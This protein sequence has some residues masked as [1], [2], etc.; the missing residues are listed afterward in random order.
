M[1]RPSR[2]SLSLLAFSV[3]VA[4]VPGP[5]APDVTAARTLELADEARGKASSRPFGV[6]SATPQGEARGESEVAV[7]LNRP[8]HALETA[9]DE[10][11]IPARIEAIGAAK[12]PTGR[13]QWMGTQA[14]VFVPEGTGM[15]GSGG[16]LP[17]ATSYR[18][19]VPAGTR[20]L[21]GSTLVADYSFTF[22]TA[23]PKVDLG[24]GV[25]VH[26]LP[27]TPTLRMVAN[28]PI[29]VRELTRATHFV[30]T[31][32][33]RAP[34]AVRITPVAA[35]KP[36]SASAV[37]AG[38][39]PSALTD[40]F[41][42]T[43]V[44]PLPLATDF[45]LRV[46]AGLH[47]LQGPL[48]TLAEM[49]FEVSTYGPLRVQEIAC[50]EA[51]DGRCAPG[52]SVRF[53][54]SNPVAWKDLRDAITVSGRP[55]PK[56]V[57]AAYD[58]ETTSSFWVA[59]PF[60]AGGAV[61]ASIRPGIKDKYGQTLQ[62][63]ASKTF[64]VGDLPSRLELGVEGEVFERK[65]GGSTRTIPVRSVNLD[66]YKLGAVALTEEQAVRAVGDQRRSGVEVAY[67]YLDGLAPKHAREVRPQVGKNRS[68]LE[69]VTLDGVLGKANGAG[70]VGVYTA[71]TYPGREQ[72]ERH[73][74]SLYRVTDLA[75]SAKLSRYGGVIW[76]TRL[77]DAAPV[78]G[79]V[80]RIRDTQEAA[81]LFE[82][83]ADANGLVN[84]PPGD[85]FT[86]S[87][88]ALGVVVAAS[89]DDWTYR[90][91]EDPNHG[92]VWP[93]MS[94]EL[95]AV[96]MLF[97]DR[98]LYRR[99]ESI[100]AKILFREEQLQGLQ[101]PAG[102]GVTLR[103][104]DADGTTIFEKSGQLGAFGE[105]AFEI[106]LGDSAPLGNVSLRAHIQDRE[107]AGT[108]YES[109]QI[110]AYRPAEFKTTTTFAK[111][112]H[113]RGD[114]AACTA[115]G[116]Y[117]FGA[118]LSQGTAR[119]TLSRRATWFSPPGQEGRVVDD[120]SFGRDVRAAGASYTVIS[121]ADPPQAGGAGAGQ[122]QG[123]AALSARG[124]ATHELT[125]RMPS[126]I[127]PESVTCEADI[128][129]VSRQSIAAE[130]TT[131]VHPGTFYLALDTPEDSIVD[132]NA[133]LAPKVRTVDPEG[134]IRNGIAV[135]LELIRRTWS[136]VYEEQGDGG[137][138]DT[139]VKDVLV[140]SCEVRT[141]Q[142]AVSC[143]L[144]AGEAGYYLVHAKAVDER[145]NP[146]GASYGFYVS[147]ESGSAGW[148]LRDDASLELVLDRASYE[149]GQTAKVLVKNPFT[150]A[151]ALVTVERANTLQKLR[152]H[153][154]GPAPVIKLPVGADV[155]PN[156]YVTVELV[157]GRIRDGADPA[158]PVTEPASSARA[159]RATR[160][161]RKRAK[162]A[163]RS[164]AVD[165]G[166]PAYRIG[167]I[168]LPVNP[169]SRRLTATVK[170]PR[171]QYG[172]GEQLDADIDVR[173]VAGKGAETD[174][175]FYVV[176]EGVL[177]LSGYKT[178]D[179]V[180]RFSAGLPL[181]V[182]TFESRGEL[183]KLLKFRAALGEDKGYDG[184]G[185]GDGVRAD[186]RTTA[187]FT[188]VKTD[189]NGHAHVRSKLP[190]GLT[191]Y[192]L[193]AVVAGK[194]DRFGFGESRVTT[195]RPLM[196]RPALP[197]FLRAGDHIDAG[198]IVTAKGLAAGSVAVTLAVQGAVLEGPAVQTVNLGKDTSAEVRFKIRVDKVGK[199]SF[200]LRAEGM[201]QKDA[202]TLEKPVQ[203]PTTF[204]T[205]A[206]AG[207]TE[208]AVG[209]QL[210]NLDAIRA[211][212]GGL[213]VRLA[214][215]ALVGVES[216]VDQLTEYPH[217]CTE[218][219]SSR[220]LPL[221]ESKELAAFFGIQ[222]PGKPER[223]ADAAIAQIVE[224][225]HGDGGFGYWP[226]SP[227]SDPW[228]S[229]YATFVLGRAKAA[230]RAVPPRV[231]ENALSYV[232]RSLRDDSPHRSW[233]S[234]AF[235]V[236][237]LAS[238][239]QP[240]QTGPAIGKKGQP[241]PQ[242]ES[243]LAGDIHALMPPPDDAP[244]FAR[245]LLAH[246]VAAAH[247]R[248]EDQLELAKDLE[249]S[250]QITPTG[251]LVAEPRSETDRLLRRR[252]LDSD[253][254]TTAMVLRALVAIDPVHPLAPKLAKG[255]LA[256][257]RHGQYESTQEAAWV[258]LALDDYRK[259]YEKDA[260]AFDARLFLG[261]TLA[262]EAGFHGGTARA[263]ELS[264]SMDKLFAG[265]SRGN[266]PLAFQVMG[267]GTLFYE[268]RLRYARK[269]NP[270]SSLSR[271]FTVQRWLRAVDPAK[272]QEATRTLP[273]RSETAVAAGSLVLIDV[274]VVND[275][276]AYQVV[277]D[278]P[279]PA[280]LEA[281]NGA[282]LTS[283][284]SLGS[285][286]DAA[287]QR[288]DEEETDDFQYRSSWVG[289]ERKTDDDRVLTYV[290]D[291][292][293]GLHHYRYLARATTRGQFVVPPARAECMYEPEIFGRTAGYSFTV[294]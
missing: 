209:E 139:Q 49:D 88:V 284:R 160:E 17:M 264:L 78:P 128:T 29:D 144:R 94:R 159:G 133:T 148:A 129:D 200:T 294:R 246:A 280:G 155:R 108:A 21:D 196:V 204:E 89:G 4:C 118:P 163:D 138:Y 211:D 220:L 59:G 293:A 262:H 98:G 142:A 47:G 122:D 251:A 41:D 173:D 60:P 188:S 162:A 203:I 223:L 116:E 140:Q 56:S 168:A 63:G 235:A 44:T 86:G 227:S 12:P 87:G 274:L 68:A 265:D 120:D 270:T 6:V 31:T 20:A 249:R 193:M 107:E 26:T 85:Y 66:A 55:A 32:N 152:V 114:K 225:Q 104:S 149:V 237:V 119:F 151:D 97:T 292:P 185:G 219:L 23:R 228:L 226:S 74:A 48:P 58:K 158:P 178:P 291:L 164:K 70:V 135:R 35:P 289:Y 13:W 125:L 36:T 257:R 277:L 194:D 279:L 281:V 10:T 266:A 167:T 25:D 134:K 183:A 57:S 96:G 269:E 229:P 210:G 33:K 248:K 109:V 245:A 34:I 79:A 126:Q 130:S 52:G 37:A 156:A 73:T 67:R 206:L 65:P 165:L 1:R 100:H 112:S 197:R 208:K 110:A 186:F 82:G 199:A 154:K 80:I 175:T 217:G 54:L 137:H 222:M 2:S 231:L 218:Q 166:G 230:G 11:P 14:F 115:R 76:V 184:G 176:D 212:S 255:L 19:T 121:S 51:E 247:L 146:I 53:V 273:A 43:P 244:L 290:E 239:E 205:V 286:L 233:A 28:Q 91:L 190:D 157:R 267:S 40:T 124:E 131:L 254:R 153:V 50:S 77:S 39:Q 207:E 38:P 198:A 179:P 132:E 285:A 287:E 202:A 236:D 278:D 102:K 250:V 106:P 75:I 263:Q 22:A 101:N 71:V 8:L 141:G 62:A 213:D 69:S 117:L 261:G 221:I 243:G 145:Q 123:E 147:G 216:V 238:L 113:I 72:Y 242:A 169:A 83:N 27:P 201:G 42:V 103:A 224:R 3:V 187:V 258:L 174:V 195:S 276:P 271:G 84:V 260:P 111:P 136:S 177:M 282:L 215:T 256:S 268:A 180:P 240:G 61:T 150:E 105:A 189:A 15:G 95:Q 45:V 214:S 171:T 99:G 191:T 92:G 288:D 259:A 182:G 252:L 241:K 93:E 232:R 64:R 5:K 127:G 81:I 272:L 18:V 161:I 90:P 181:R 24:S 172:P 283:A 16:A 30:S 275:Q 192:R 234:H 143:P 170:T 9:G 46:D 7:V 253:R